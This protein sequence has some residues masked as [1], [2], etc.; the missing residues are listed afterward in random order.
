MSKKESIMKWL[1]EVETNDLQ[2]VGRKAFEL[3]RLKRSEFPVP[4]GFVITHSTCQEII[5]KGSNFEEGIRSKELINENAFP[6]QII[7]KISSGFRELGKSVAV[8][9]SAVEEDRQGVSFAG[10]YET[11]LNVGREK[12]LFQAI[13]S[14]FNSQFSEQVQEYARRNKISGD[15]LSLSVLIQKQIQPDFSGVLFTVNPVSGNDQEMVVEAVK[16]LGEPLVD[17]KVHP[18]RYMIN[19]FSEKVISQAFSMDQI[20]VLTGPDEGVAFNNIQKTDVLLD[21]NILW[22]LVRMAMRIQT[23]YGCP[24]DIEWAVADRKVYILQTRP[25]TA[26]GYQGINEEWTTAD[27]RDGGVSSEVVTPFMWS[28]YERVF[29]SAMNTYLKEIHLIPRNDKTRWSKVFFGRP[30]WNV[31]AVKKALAKMPGF[32]ERNFDQDL[33]IEITYDT[34]GVVTPFSLMGVLRAIPVM[35]ALKKMYYDQHVKTQK[36]IIRFKRYLKSFKMK[37]LLKMKDGNLE[38]LFEDLV[39][40][41]HFEMETAYFKTIFN[42]A[43]ARL[44]F[45]SVF[46]KANKKGACLQYLPLITA[47][48]PLKPVI[49]LFKLW[50]IS[51]YVRRDM[52]AIHVLESGKIDKI[53]T[54]PILGKALKNFIEKYG[55]HSTRELDL[56]IPRWSEDPTFIIDTLQAYAKLEDENNPQAHVSI[57]RRIYENELDKLRRFFSGFKRIQRV[58]FMKKL[59]NVRLHTWYKEEVRDWSTWAYSLIRSVSLE[60]GRR[61][62]QRKILDKETDIFYLS[63]QEIIDLLKDKKPDIKSI[64]RRIEANKAYMLSFRHFE[65]PNE[66]GRRWNYRYDR[67]EKSYGDCEKYKGIPCSSGETKGIV[68]I[69]RDIGEADKLRAGDIL[70]TRFTDPGWTPLFPLISG[71]ITETGGILSHAA[72]IAREY[73]IPAVLA[74]R[75]ATDNLADGQMVIIDGN[76]GEVQILC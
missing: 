38:A 70:V 47:L 67:M 64:R 72:V 28:L 65:N 45:K 57:N 50:E 3:A 49:P 27:F 33:G 18:H 25:V 48:R 15:A 7:D 8:R 10:Q 37:N 73:G 61:L 52:K 59:N 30:Y 6:E 39:C 24:Q 35:V 14:C 68:R 41:R 40:H 66:I 36:A 44:E 75:K 20:E 63:C 5:S 32:N 55:H 56:R 74:V 31:G 13:E 60:V 2:K 69:I 9:S 46:D 12:D 54:H 71:V 43:N 1:E 29:E 34:D 11:V 21:D 76:K 42:T 62:V 16:G 19:G 17:G 58:G 23:M 51:R 4:D 26:M 22:D 53:F